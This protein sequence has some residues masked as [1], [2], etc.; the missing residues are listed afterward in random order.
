[1]NV[2]RIMFNTQYIAY[3]GH[4]C[5]YTTDPHKDQLLPKGI[6]LN[7]DDIYDMGRCSLSYTGLA[8]VM[9]WSRGCQQVSLLRSP[10]IFMKARGGLKVFEVWSSHGKTRSCSIT[11]FVLNSSCKKC[12]GPTD[13]LFLFT[14]KRRVFV[15]QGNEAT[16]GR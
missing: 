4:G 15:R 7:I 8:L 1:M 6:I 12:I 2:S 5:Y 10:Y 16:N 11:K 14:F 9:C 3:F 13:V